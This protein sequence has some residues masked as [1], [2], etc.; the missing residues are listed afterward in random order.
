MDKQVTLQ[1][2]VQSVSGDDLRIAMGGVTLY[3]RP[4]AFSLALLAHNRH[5]SHP[6]RLTLINFTAGLESDLL[7]GEGMVASVRTCYFGLEVFG[8]APHFTQAA[9]AGTLSIVE[10][11]EGSL[12]CG[13]RAS[14]SGV[15]FMPSIGWLGTDLPKLRPDVKTIVDPYSGEELIAFPAIEIDVAIIHALQADPDGNALIGGN[16]GVDEELALVADHVIVTTEEIVP[17]LDRADLIGPA[18]DAVVEAK[19][20]AWPTSCHPLYPLDGNALLDYIEAADGTDYDPL[21]SAWCGHHGI[22]LPG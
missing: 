6:E 22:D 5:H 18:V 1:E 9:A 3:R 17:A 4:M 14:M 7:V 11:T 2:A 15:G 19:Q 13:L 12:A 8:L 20:G 21:L 10:E 16:P